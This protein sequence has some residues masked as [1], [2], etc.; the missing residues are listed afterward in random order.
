MPDD[1]SRSG[2]GHSLAPGRRGRGAD[3]LIYHLHNES[4]ISADDV[5]HL[6]CAPRGHHPAG[7]PVV[8]AFEA[9]ATYGCELSGEGASS[10][11]YDHSI[12][13]EDDVR[14]GDG[15]SDKFMAKSG[16][17]SGTQA[18][19]A[20]TTVPNASGYAAVPAS[21]LANIG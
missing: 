19:A 14:D 13:W 18:D 17:S 7:H 11:M 2:E 10:G 9:L 4:S 12:G 15:N 8:C 1:W 20:A 6:D 3:Y 16:A 21:G 5:W